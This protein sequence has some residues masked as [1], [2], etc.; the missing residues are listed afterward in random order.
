[1]SAL[2]VLQPPGWPRPSGYSNG[3]TASGRWIL[4]AGLIGWDE[5]GRFADDLVSQVAQTLRNA[6][7]VLAEGGARPEHVARMTWFVV[8]K[9]DYLRNASAIGAVYR[10]VMGRHFPAMSVLEVSALLED[11]ARVEIEFT[12]VVPESEP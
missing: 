2:R 12:A 9:Q 4:T 3:I 6:V 5:N 7:A 1:L 8:D 11:Q 10:E